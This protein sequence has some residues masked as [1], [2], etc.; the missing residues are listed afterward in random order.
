MSEKKTGKPCI[1]V[2]TTGTNLYDKGE[3]AAYLAL[4][5]EFAA[6]KKEKKAG[7]V[8][9]IGATPLNTGLKTADKIIEELGKNASDEY[10]DKLGFIRDIKDQITPLLIQKI[11]YLTLMGKK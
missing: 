1:T 10:K 11:R 3:E 5:K 8:G 6:E 7:K 4:F 2:E 9:V